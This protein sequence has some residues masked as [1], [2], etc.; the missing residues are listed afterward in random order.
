MRLEAKR[1]GKFPGAGVPLSAAG[2]G[3]RGRVGRTPERWFEVVDPDAPPA[4]PRRWSWP[5]FVF[6]ALLCVAAVGLTAV[7]KGL[8]M[9]VLLPLPL[10]GAG[11]L[12]LRRMAWMAR[13]ELLARK[14]A[15]KGEAPRAGRRGLRLGG[16]RLSYQGR[17]GTSPSLLLDAEVPFGVTLLSSPRRDRVVALLSSPLGAFYVG[18]VFDAATQRA[19]AP[20]LGRTTIVAADEVGLAAIGPD[21]EPLFLAPESLAALVEA[22]MAMAP[23]CQDR[24]LLTDARGAPVGLEGREMRAG[25][26]SFDLDT[27]LEWRAFVFQEALGQAVA[28]YQGTWVRQGSSEIV[29]VCLLPA[30]TPRPEG[31]GVPLS[32]LDREALRDLRLMQGRPEAPP[33]QAQRVAVDRLVM[34]PIRSALDRAP[35]SGVPTPRAQA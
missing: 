20:M 1:E 3:L 32:S 16:G 33:A 19:F 22:L 14:L 11:G 15:R 17:E 29:L 30:L 31:E 10:M 35:R 18:A 7:G 13:P 12:L 25:G 27:A 21:G 2:G 8:A 28:L 26:R 23:G 24:V 5:S 4:E 9:R 6:A 34:L